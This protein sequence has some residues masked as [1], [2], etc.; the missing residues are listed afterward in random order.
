MEKGTDTRSSR[1]FMV[2]ALVL[3]ASLFLGLLGVGGLVL[4][5]LVSGPTDVA[6]PPPEPSALPTV[7][8]AP[9]VAPP[10][11]V[12]TATLTPAPTATLV[13]AAQTTASPTVETAQG[14]NGQDGPGMS[15]PSPES[16]EMP[17]TGLGLLDT[18]G[19]GLALVVILAATRLGRHMKVGE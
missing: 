19:I 1:L 11:P 12:P 8:E 2:I 14:G 6:M 9:T 13:V 10:S 7:T 4:L 18:L 16:P 15:S 17:Q 3:T 5:R